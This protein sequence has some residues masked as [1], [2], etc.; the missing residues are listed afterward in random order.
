MSYR[1][2]ALARSL[3]MTILKT[4]LRNPGDGPAVQ[5]CVSRNIVPVREVSSLLVCSHSRPLNILQFPND[6]SYNIHLTI[7]SFHVAETIECKCMESN[8]KMD[9]SVLDQYHLQDMTTVRTIL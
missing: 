4:G 6:Q 3:S 5:A 8:E 2:K 1:R 7:I 9:F